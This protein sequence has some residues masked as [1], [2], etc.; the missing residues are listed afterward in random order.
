MNKVFK[1]ETPTLESVVVVNEFSEVFPENLPRVYLERKIKFQIDHLQDT[2][3]ILIA[4]YG[5]TPVKINELNEKFKDIIDKG[6][7]P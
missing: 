6:I 3:P 1:L 2:Q 5:M 7:S 4:L